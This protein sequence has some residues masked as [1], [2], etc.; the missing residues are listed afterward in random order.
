MLVAFSPKDQ[1]GAIDDDQTL[2]LGALQCSFQFE[3]SDGRDIIL[4]WMPTGTLRV[5]AVHPEWTLIADIQVITDMTSCDGTQMTAGQGHAYVMRGDSLIDVVLHNLT[6]V[7]INISALGFTPSSAI[8]TGVPAGHVCNAPDFPDNPA[9]DSVDGWISIE[10]DLVPVGSTA[11]TNFL[12]RFRNQIARSLNVGINRV[13]VQDIYKE[14]EGSSNVVHMLFS[15]PT[16]HDAN[17]KKGEALLDQLMTSDLDAI[18]LSIIVGVSTSDPLIQESTSIDNEDA[19]RKSWPIGAKVG[20]PLLVGG[21]AIASTTAFIC[22]K[23]RGEKALVYLE[24]AEGAQ[25]A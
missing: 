12:M 17:Q 13:F 4:V 16:Q 18:G 3:R 19:G 9:T 14:S 20:L 8:V 24:K 7:E 15:D 11:M 21:I 1:Q 6:G 2:N 22:Y 25:S 10:K 5:Y 23:K